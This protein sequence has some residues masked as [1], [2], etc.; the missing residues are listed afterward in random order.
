MGWFIPENWTKPWFGAT[1]LE[2]PVIV[3]SQRCQ[4][5]FFL[6]VWAKPQLTDVDRMTDN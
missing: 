4:R 2:S 1:N 3:D 5:G 6:A